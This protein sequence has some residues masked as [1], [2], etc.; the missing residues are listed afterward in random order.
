MWGQTGLSPRFPRAG[1]RL[2]GLETAAVLQ[3]ADAE[4]TFG[5]VSRLKVVISSRSD[6][7]CGEVLRGLMKTLR[8]LLGGGAMIVAFVAASSLSFATSDMAKK[9]KKPC[10]TCHE[11]K[12]PKG[13]EGKKL[14][15][16]GK[17]YKEKKTLDGA[18]APK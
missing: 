3:G 18:P 15:A 16:V 12:M 7:Y 5:S 2:D 11:S 10:I 9:E 17:F 13:E 8:M 1:G 4:Q 6:R 14:N